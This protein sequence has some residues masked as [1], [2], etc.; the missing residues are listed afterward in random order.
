MIVCVSVLA[1]LLATAAVNSPQHAGSRMED[2]DTKLKLNKEGK[3]MK[4]VCPCRDLSEWWRRR[5]ES[6]EEDCNLISKLTSSSLTC[7]SL[8]FW[9]FSCSRHALIFCHTH[10]NLIP[11]SFGDPE[12]SCYSKLLH[13]VFYSSHSRLLLLSTSSRLTYNTTLNR[14]E[15]GGDERALCPRAPYSYS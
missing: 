13:C 12:H 4:E 5:R 10:Y 8:I 14:S 6:R 15:I 3:W 7:L 11:C 2:R 1:S 9:R